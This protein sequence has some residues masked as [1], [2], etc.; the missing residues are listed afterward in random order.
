M[1]EEREDIEP[2]TDGEDSADVMRRAERV[3]FALRIAQSLGATGQARPL[4]IAFQET[5]SRVLPPGDGTGPG[6]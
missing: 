5:V 4:A 2:E 1:H 6:A 3:D